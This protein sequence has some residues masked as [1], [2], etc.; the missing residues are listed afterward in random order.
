MV[1]GLNRYL[2]TYPVLSTSMCMCLR[3]PQLSI[4]HDLPAGHIDRYQLSK[5][6]RVYVFKT[7]FSNSNMRKEDGF[8][9]RRQCYQA[10]TLAIRSSVR[11]NL[12]YFSS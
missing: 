7:M 8:V 1:L 11:Y 9:G 10:F 2:G 5:V 4:A 6:V 12:D 3:S